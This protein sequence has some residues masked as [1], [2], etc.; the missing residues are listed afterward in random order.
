LAP[1]EQY[2]PSD[3]PG[4]RTGDKASAMTLFDL[5]ADPAEQHDVAKAHP[6]VVESLKMEY[7]QIAKDAPETKAVK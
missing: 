2:Q 4:V 7:N 3:Y 6:E 5:A 1:F